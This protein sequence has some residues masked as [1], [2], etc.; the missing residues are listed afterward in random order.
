MAKTLVREVDLDGNITWDD[1]TVPD[2][3]R[4]R[5]VPD[6]K[7]LHLNFDDD[8]PLEDDH[9]GYGRDFVA[10]ND[11]SRTY[12]PDFPPGA[13]QDITD[14]YEV[15]PSVNWNKILDWF[16]TNN[17]LNESPFTFKIILQFTESPVPDT[18]FQ[19]L[20]NNE[21]TDS[22]GNIIPAGEVFFDW[23]IIDSQLYFTIKTY[24][25]VS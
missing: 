20:A 22:N 5:Q 14:G 13:G 21:T 6:F 16:G 18:I 9:S 8:T 17:G 1:V 19:F 4:P 23:G 3:D 2:A 7:F 25:D 24:G 11:P 15:D 10:L 12:V